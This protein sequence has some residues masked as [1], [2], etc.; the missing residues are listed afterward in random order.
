MKTRSRLQKD[1]LSTPAPEESAMRLNPHTQ[2]LSALLCS[3]ACV[4]ARKTNSLCCAAVGIT[5]PLGATAEASV[6]HEKLRE[7]ATSD[8]TL[9]AQN[10]PPAQPVLR[11]KQIHNGASA[12]EAT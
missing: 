9:I 5:T 12:Q 8:A 1:Q 7:A 11:C 4:D 3:D 10:R 2:N 6:P